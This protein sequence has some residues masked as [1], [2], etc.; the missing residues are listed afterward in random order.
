METKLFENLHLGEFIGK[1][2]YDLKERSGNSFS[3]EL[4]IRKARI[5]KILGPGD[6]RIQVQPLPEF[7]KINEEEMENL[8]CY[9]MFRKGE[10]ITGNSIKDSK[11]DDKETSEYVVCLCTRDF[12]VGYILGKPNVFGSG[13]KEEKFNDSYSW[14]DVRTFLAQRQALPEDFEYKNLMVTTFFATDKGGMINCYNRK[15][16]DWVLLNTT[17]SIITVQQKEI[18]MRVGSPPNPVSSGPVGFS[19]IKMT[20]D[21]IHFKAPNIEFDY[22]DL[23]LGHN[24][25]VLG[26]LLTQGPVIGRNGVSVN[27][28]STIHV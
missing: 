6:D 24:G 1:D 10:V 25:M 16:G 19:M 26:G 13:V 5:Y 27:P 3:D 12:S 8:P 14:S 2:P 23:V 15:T 20:G 17:G 28:V 21:K 7:M 18:Y 22:N 9:P 11:K 4:I